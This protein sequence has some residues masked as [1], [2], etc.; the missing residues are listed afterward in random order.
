[1]AI[2]KRESRETAE[3]EFAPSLPKVGEAI[4]VGRRKGV[5][6]SVDMISRTPWPSYHISIELTA[7]ATRKRRH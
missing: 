1:M 6:T 5:V 7:K 4:T 3:V 2:F